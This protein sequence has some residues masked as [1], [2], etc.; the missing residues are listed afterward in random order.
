[1]EKRKIIIDVDTGHDDAIAIMMAMLC[2][3]EFDILGI[4]TVN[5]NVSR[6]Y[7]KNTLRVG[8]FMGGR[9][10]FTE[11]ANI[12]WLPHGKAPT[13]E[14]DKPGE[15]TADGFGRTSEQL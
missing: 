3:D 6:L 2:K 4:A 11:V 5:G 8:E 7:N 12:L 9:F 14:K 13:S 1:M 10:P 15:K